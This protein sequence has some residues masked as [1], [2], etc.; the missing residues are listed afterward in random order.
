MI[1]LNRS[2]TEQDVTGAYNIFC[3]VFGLEPKIEDKHDITIKW[4]T[5]KRAAGLHYTTDRFYFYLRHHD[6][7]F[8]VLGF[9]KTINMKGGKTQG[10]ENRE[11]EERMKHYFLNKP[12]G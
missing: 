8:N 6:G 12:V 1:S 5:A 11:F 10:P 9:N 2:L 7:N 3:D 4:H